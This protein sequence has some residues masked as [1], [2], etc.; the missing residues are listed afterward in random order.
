MHRESW[1]QANEVPGLNRQ[2]QDLHEQIAEAI[3]RHDSEQA[4]S[5]TRRMLDLS[6]DRIQALLEEEWQTH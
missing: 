1:A 6:T 4:Q 3:A 2:G 5:L